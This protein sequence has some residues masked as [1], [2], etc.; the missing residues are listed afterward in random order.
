MSSKQITLKCT[1]WIIL[2]HL[3]N[4]FFKSK[5]ETTFNDCISC[6]QRVIYNS[7][8]KFFFTNNDNVPRGTLLVIENRYVSISF[9]IDLLIRSKYD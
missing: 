4:H 1:T 2:C 8:K 9:K 5:V 3:K 7:S 6:K